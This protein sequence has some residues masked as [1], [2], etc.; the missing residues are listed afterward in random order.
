M[1]LSGLRQPR[2]LIIAVAALAVFANA[3]AVVY[4]AARNRAQFSE[5]SHL[6]SEHDRL[7]IRRGQLE[8][9]EWT[10]AAHARVAHLAETEMDMQAPSKVRIVRVP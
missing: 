10:L 4:S 5:L 1:K 7:V 6:R 9:E 3:L 8:L 2:V